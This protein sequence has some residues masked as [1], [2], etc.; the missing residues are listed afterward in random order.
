MPKAGTAERVE[1]II[2]RQRH[3]KHVSAATD[4][5]A[6]TEFVVLSRSPLL[7]QLRGKQIQ[8]LLEVSLSVCSH[9]RLYNVHQ[10][11]ISRE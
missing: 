1:A 10:Q 5:D 9:S 11:P 7:G 2:A 3:G 6:T 8:G 4:T